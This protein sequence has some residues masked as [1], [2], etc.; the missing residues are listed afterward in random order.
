MIFLREFHIYPEQF[1]K[2]LNFSTW[3]EV[4]AI[5]EKIVSP[6]LHIMNFCCV[7]EMAIHEHLPAEILN[8][9]YQTLYNLC[10]TFLPNMRVAISKL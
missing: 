1:F 2:N 10:G 6:L 5:Q 4:A 9:H 8:V 7:E 3:V